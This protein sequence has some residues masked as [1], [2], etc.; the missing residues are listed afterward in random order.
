MRRRSTGLDSCSTGGGVHHY[1][2]DKRR[3]QR[4]NRCS[5]RHG[6]FWPTFIVLLAAVVASYVNLEGFLSVVS[7]ANTW[8]LDKFAWLY[9]LGGLYLLVLAA[10]VYFSKLGRIRIGGDKATPLITKRRWFLS[11]CAPPWQ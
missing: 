3:L 2:V 8:V 5:V 10:L 6:V 7:T 9:S 4:R 1:S 11:P